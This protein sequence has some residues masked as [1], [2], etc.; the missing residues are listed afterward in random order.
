MEHEFKTR[1]DL[2]AWFDTM[3]YNYTHMNELPHE[4]AQRIKRWGKT[5]PKLA[6]QVPGYISFW[7]D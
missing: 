2:A 4:T 6:E 1:D 7:S 3:V 5:D